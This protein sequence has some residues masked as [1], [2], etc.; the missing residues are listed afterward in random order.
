M[1]ARLRRRWQRDLNITNGRGHAVRLGLFA[2]LAQKSG[3]QRRFDL[4]FGR[5]GAALANDPVASNLQHLATG[6]ADQKC[7]GRLAGSL[8][9]RL[10]IDR[11]T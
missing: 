3:D 1:S 10:G 9:L 2:R 6:S 8:D 11:C 4:N 7:S 5:K